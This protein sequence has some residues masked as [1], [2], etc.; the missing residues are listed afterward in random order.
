MNLYKNN[1]KKVKINQ[2]GDRKMI[3][4]KEKIW[5]GNVLLVVFL[6]ILVTRSNVLNANKKKE[7]Q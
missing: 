3:N 5:D 6:E 1:N 7:M 2:L 4:M